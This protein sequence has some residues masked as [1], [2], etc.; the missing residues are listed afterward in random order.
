MKL[1]KQNGGR[2]QITDISKDELDNIRSCIE[3]SFED[4]MPKVRSLAVKIAADRLEG[5]EE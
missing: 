2:Y 1:V 3:V 4:A 5:E